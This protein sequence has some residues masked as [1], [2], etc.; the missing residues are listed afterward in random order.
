MWTEHMHDFVP[1]DMVSFVLKDQRHSVLYETITN[2]S[3]RTIRGAY[4]VK[5]G[6]NVKSISCIVMDP[7]KNVIY[8]KSSASQHIILFDSTVAGEYAF[9]FGNFGSR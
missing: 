7:L 2:Q 4:Y 9:M 1:E 8:K 3:S 6:N 5:G